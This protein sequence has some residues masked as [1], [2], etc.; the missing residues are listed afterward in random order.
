MESAP[1]RVER[2]NSGPFTTRSEVMG[3]QGMV[4]SSQPLSTQ[5]GL[6]TLKRGGTAVDAAI[7][8]NAALGLMEPTGGGIGGDLYALV[9]DAASGT[10]Y[11]LNAVAGRRPD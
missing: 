3:A 7:A 8:V 1:M 2:T 9:W 4:A 6:D 10:V 5:V 11:G